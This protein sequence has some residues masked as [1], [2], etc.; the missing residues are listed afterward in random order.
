MTNVYDSI[1]RNIRQAIIYAKRLDLSSVHP[2][3][4]LATTGFCLAR[5]GDQYVIYQ[6]QNKPLEVSA[7]VPRADYLYE[8]YDCDKNHVVERNRFACS[9]E[10]K[11]FSPPKKRMV[12]FLER[13]APYRTLSLPTH[14]SVAEDL[15]TMGANKNANNL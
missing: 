3:S 5:P 15:H 6:P 4:D 1:R 9:Q 8:W 14:H 10:N 11:L 7:L 2:R 12:L 13:Y